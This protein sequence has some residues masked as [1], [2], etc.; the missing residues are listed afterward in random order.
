LLL[1][2]LFVRRKTVLA[3]LSRIPYLVRQGDYMA[4]NDLDSGYWQVPIFPP[5]QTY[6]GLS[7]QHDDKSY[8]FW[9]WVV[10]L[11]GIVD[12]AHIFTTLTDPLISLAFY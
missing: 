10:M 11:L 7:F 2:V 5:H 9:V 1:V 6:L 8:Y 3:D 12:A 4:V